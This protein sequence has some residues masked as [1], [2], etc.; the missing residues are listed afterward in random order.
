MVTSFNAKKRD[1]F[2]AKQICGLPHKGTHKKK[3]GDNSE[4]TDQHKS[5]R[6]K[7]HQQA[8]DG[9]QTFMRHY[10]SSKTFR[11]RAHLPT[12]P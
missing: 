6:H 12:P 1:V 2:L 7:S 9:M 8:K 10:N 4:A 11:G 3:L 5:S